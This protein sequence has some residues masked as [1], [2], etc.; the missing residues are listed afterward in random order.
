MRI[1]DSIVINL[2]SRRRFA[3]ASDYATQFATLDSSLQSLK[4]AGILSQQASRLSYI[5][6]DSVSFRTYSNRS[7]S[8]LRRV[9][10]QSPKDEESLLYLGLALVESGIPANSMQGILTIRSVLEINPDN[11]DASYQLGLFSVQTGQLEKALQRFKKVLELQPD[12][13]EA[14]LQ[15]ANVYIQTDNAAE[16]RP[17]LEAVLKSKTADSELK[18]NAGNLINS[19]Q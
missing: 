6:A 5:Q 18:R 14:M 12:H 9:V 4:R 3:Y 2:Q 1:L 15:L 17:L 7:L 8:Y 19:I 11:V 16:A 10:A 13:A